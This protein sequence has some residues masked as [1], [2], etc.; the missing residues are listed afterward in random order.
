MKIFI[1]KFKGLKVIKSKV[2]KDSRG[3]FK[4]TF[5]KKFFKN[6]NFI[7]G[8]A[9]YSK[10]NVL[11]GMHIQK[12]FSQGK[13]VTVLKGEILDV[14]VDLRKNSKTF[15]KHYKIVLS[16]ENGKSIF[17]PPGFAHGFL[18]R[19][20]DNIIFYYCTNYRSA[21]NELG[22]KWN[23]KK[24]KIKWP[25]KKPILSKKDKKNISFLDYVKSHA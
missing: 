8:C 23:D 16:S 25:I 6:E 1:T 12:K 24:L 4:E 10:K 17:I 11:R 14:V 13:Y 22:L 9:S 3:Y 5:K 15:G 21:K 18:G 2:H 20:K 7:F 19:K